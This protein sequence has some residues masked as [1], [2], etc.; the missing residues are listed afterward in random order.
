MSRIKEYWRKIVGIY[1]DGVE[2]PVKGQSIS[3]TDR[4]AVN[5]SHPVQDY[6]K[7]ELG[8]KQL[9]LPF[10]PPIQVP[11]QLNPKFRPKTLRELD[12]EHD[13]KFQNFLVVLNGQDVSLENKQLI[14]KTLFNN[15]KTGDAYISNRSQSLLLDLF[16]SKL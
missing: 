14:L 1:K 12:R 2:S 10:E 16:S 4:D 6:A 9:E 8:T 5:L 7:A 15:I 13:E 3:Y 11:Q